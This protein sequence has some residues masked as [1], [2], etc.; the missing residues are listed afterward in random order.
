[1]TQRVN[2]GA[3][4]LFAAKPRR[5]PVIAQVSMRRRT[6][7]CAPAC[8]G[9]ASGNRIPLVAKLRIDLVGE[10]P[11]LRM[12]AQDCGDGFDVLLRNDSPGGILRRIQDQ[13]PGLRRDLRFEFGGSKL[14]LRDSRK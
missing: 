4:A 13:Q 6:E 3:S 9:T 1:V 10:Y 8:R 7:W 11:D 12:F 2:T 14:K 5:H